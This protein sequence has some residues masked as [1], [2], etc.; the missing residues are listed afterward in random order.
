MRDQPALAARL[1]EQ[2]FQTYLARHCTKAF[3]GNVV[4]ALP[5]TD[6]ARPEMRAA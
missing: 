4:A 2:A 5:L 3:V 1:S 6:S